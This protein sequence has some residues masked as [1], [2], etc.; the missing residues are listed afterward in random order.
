MR[1][2][3]QMD[4]ACHEVWAENP[5]RGDAPRGLISAVTQWGEATASWYSS[6]TAAREVRRSLWHSSL[7]DCTNRWVFWIPHPPPFAITLFPTIHLFF[8][9][10]QAKDKRRWMCSRSAVWELQ[11]YVYCNLALSLSLGSAFLCHHVLV[12]QLEVAAGLR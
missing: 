5:C 8:E 9:T 11:G 4:R 3:L 1:S 6:A 12:L 7:L 10:E 2:I